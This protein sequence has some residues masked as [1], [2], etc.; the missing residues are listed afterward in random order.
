MRFKLLSRLA[1]LAGFAFGGSAHAGLVATDFWSAGDGYLVQDD[2][3]P[4]EWLSPVA[5]RNHAWGDALIQTLFSQ[6]FRYATRTEVLTLL[7][8]NFGLATTTSPG[9]AAGFAIAQNFFDVFGVAER[10]RCFRGGWVDCPR[11][12]GLTAEGVGSDGHIAVGMMQ[13]GAG[14]FLIDNN[15]WPNSVPDAQVGSWLV[16]GGDAAQN[17]PEPG[18]L[19][20]LAVAATVAWPLSRRRKSL[21]NLA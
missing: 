4:R 19:A 10:V 14:G 3:S 2:A 6:G 15:P 18:S 8:A 13:F 12:Q 11:T 17:L 16:R 21:G 9:D 20:L 1:L 5:T 7:D